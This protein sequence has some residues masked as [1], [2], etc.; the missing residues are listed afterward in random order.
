MSE[1]AAGICRLKCFCLCF[2]WT[3]RAKP[4]PRI[5]WEGTEGGLRATRGHG[6]A[7]PGEA[8]P[9]RHSDPTSGAGAR[10]TAAL[11][12]L[13]TSEEPARQA[14]TGLRAHGAHT[15]TRVYAEPRATAT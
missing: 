7:R 12:P 2:C 15:H 9:A 8:G 5:P 6:G 10:V 13:I 14:G 11:G 4:E 3:F 1:A